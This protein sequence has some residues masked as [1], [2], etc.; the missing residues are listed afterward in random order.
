MRF[1]FIVLVASL[2]GCDSSAGGGS[3]ASM[4][5]ATQDGSADDA[6]IDA[7]PV[8]ICPTEWCTEVAPIPSTVDLRAVSVVTPSDVFAV[9]KGGVIL[10]RRNNEWSAMQSNT[11]A[12]LYGVWALSGSD[13]WAVGDGGVVL[14]WD[15][16]SWAQVA[17][18]LDIDYFGVWGSAADHVVLI[19]TTKV[20][21]WNG[22]SWST[23]TI[24]GALNS[25][26][27][28]GPNDVWIATEPQGLHHFTQTWDTVT[29]G[30]GNTIFAVYAV[31]ANDVWIS[32]PGVDTVHF[33]GTS[34]TVRSAANASFTD[35]YASTSSDVWG[36]SQATVGRWSGT[37]WAVST[38]P[39]V[40]D[41]LRAVDGRDGHVWVVG[42]GAMILH[43]N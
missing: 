39:G 21:T 37:S 9:G 11:T 32:A 17:G 14:R 10:R 34:W 42:A 29:T 25:V 27:G 41:T 7:P 23:R 43:R 24:A 5:G 20:Q 30:A 40:T 1:A 3:D 31:A 19:G 4:D 22:S 15:G 16:N 18:V 38:P 13:A 12:D 26:H 2:F 8:T 6:A 33:N 28:L 36:V 35:F